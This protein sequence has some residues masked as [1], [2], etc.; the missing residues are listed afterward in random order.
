ML[1]RRKK[2]IKNFEPSWTQEF[3][4]TFKGVENLENSE[5]NNKS[6]IKEEAYQIID[7]IK[8]MSDIELKDWLDMLVV[9]SFSM[10]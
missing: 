9:R 5:S 1:M 7:K 3:H 10:G 6:A 2:Y 8:A 4:D